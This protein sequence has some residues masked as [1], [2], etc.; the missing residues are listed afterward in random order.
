MSETKISAAIRKMIRAEFPQII[1]DRMHCGCVK[2]RGGYMKLAEPGWPDYVG[3]L[4]DGRFI[5]IEVKDPDGTTNKKRA[6]LQAA[7]LADINSKGGVGII[8]SSVE[9]CRAQLIKALMPFG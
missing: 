7:R 6:E 1:F 2:V 5:G 8:T 3:F 4:P 9:D